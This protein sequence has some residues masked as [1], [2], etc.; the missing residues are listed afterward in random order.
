M[1]RRKTGLD[2]KIPPEA[3]AAPGLSSFA[4]WCHCAQHPSPLPK[5]SWEIPGYPALLGKLKLKGKMSLNFVFW[6]GFWVF[7]L[8]SNHRSLV[9]SHGSPLSCRLWECPWEVPRNQ[10]RAALFTSLGQHRWWTN[11]QV[12]KKKYRVKE[13]T[14]GTGISSKADY[15]VGGKPV[16][17]GR[18][19]RNKIN[20]G[21]WQLCD[22]R[23]WDEQTDTRPINSWELKVYK[24]WFLSRT[25]TLQDLNSGR[26][27]TTDSVSAQPA[28]DIL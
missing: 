21:L 9:L 3:I 2:A 13:R 18:K 19:K 22:D 8:C 17:R 16:D 4:L 26:E 28:R 15:G 23:H 10:R 5:F 25:P 27:K 12:R 7:S 24:G 6:I 20:T 14:K 11:A 1:P